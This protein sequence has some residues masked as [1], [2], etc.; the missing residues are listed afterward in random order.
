MHLTGSGAQRRWRIDANLLLHPSFLTIAM[1]KNEGCKSRLASIL[2]RRCAPEP[3]RCIENE[4]V[5]P[6]FAH[7]RRG[8]DMADDM[9]SAVKSPAVRTAG[10]RVPQ[11][12]HDGS[13]GSAVR[14]VPSRP[15]GGRLR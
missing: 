15:E 3:V 4:K 12:R 9:A 2:H 14:R 5:R 13:S 7:R 8:D 1:V 6:Y 10:Y 11:Q